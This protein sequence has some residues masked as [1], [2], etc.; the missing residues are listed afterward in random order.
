MTLEELIAAVPIREFRGRPFYVRISDIPPP[1]DGQF[2]RA[3]SGAGCPG[4]EGEGPCAYSHDWLSW[5]NGQWWGG[6]NVPTG[7][8]PSQ[9]HIDYVCNAVKAVYGVTPDGLTAVVVDAL[10]VGGKLSA[11]DRERLGK[12]VEPHIL[13]LI[14]KCA[15]AAKRV[16]Q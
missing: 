3:L 2:S 12:Q 7:L 15:Q 11:A 1:W 10:K 16:V 13:D 4:F 8:D 9:H 14:E 5:A 6:A